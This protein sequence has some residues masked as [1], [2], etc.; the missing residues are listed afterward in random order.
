[1]YL[2][3]GFLPRLPRAAR[4]DPRTIAGSGPSTTGRRDRHRP[5]SEL[6]KNPLN[7]INI[8]FVSYF[9]EGGASVYI[10]ICICRCM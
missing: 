5:Q 7:K 4:H 1:M 6:S 2:Y 10:Y 3:K 9:R 8:Y